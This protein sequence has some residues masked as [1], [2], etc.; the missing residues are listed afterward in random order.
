MIGDLPPNSPP[1]SRP[2]PSNVAAVRPLIRDLSVASWPTSGASPEAY[3]AETEHLGRFVDRGRRHRAAL[4]AMLSRVR[5]ARMRVLADL[6]DGPPDRSSPALAALLDAVTES[7]TFVDSVRL[8]LLET[9]MSGVRPV[10]ARAV[11][12][13]R[14]P[15]PSD[16][17]RDRVL[18]AILE[19]VG[20]AEAGIDPAYFP[21]AVVRHRSL[22]EQI[23]ELEAERGR[24]D[25][26]P[27][28][29][30]DGDGEAL[31]DLDRRLDEL[32]ARRDALADVGIESDG[33]IEPLDA[34]ALVAE[35]TGGSA[36]E[37]RY[38]ASA[39]VEH[40]RRGLAGGGSGPG[41]GSPTLVDTGGFTAEFDHLG[42]RVADDAV[43][44]AG[45][46][47]ELGPELSAELPT[48]VIGAERGASL[49]DA[50]PVLDQLASGLA[51]TTRLDG[52][53]AATL[54]FDGG[55]LLAQPRPSTAAGVVGHSPALLFAAG[56]FDDRFLADATITVLRLG[57]AGDP[58]GH[59]GRFGWH[60]SSDG[61][62]AISAVDPGED[63]R[64]L[65]L[66]RAAERPEVARLV[67]D[68]LDDG[69]DDG[70]DGGLVD[71]L[72]GVVGE[73]PVA[74][75]GLGPLV[76]PSVGFRPSM[77]PGLDAYPITA[78]L[79]AVAS[80][81]DASVRI[82]RAVAD[83]A[84]ATGSADEATIGDPGTAAGL[85]V[86]LGANAALVIDPDDVR[87][88]GLAPPGG[89]AGL[90]RPIDPAQWRAV[91]GEVHRWGRGE[92][93]AAATADLAATA[94]TGAIDADG[95][96]HVDRVAP[97][98]QLAG[99]AEAEAHR[100]RLSYAVG[101]DDEA[102]SWNRQASRTVAVANTALGL[103]PVV[104]PSSIPAGL[105]WTFLFEGRPTDA[106]LREHRDRWAAHYEDGRGHRWTSAVA[107]GWLGWALAGSGTAEVELIVPGRGHQV[108]ELR[109]TGQ[110]GRFHWRDPDTDAWSLLDTGFESQ[111]L[112]LAPHGSGVPLRR[113]ID[114]AIEIDEEFRDGIIAWR[115]PEPA[116]HSPSGD[117]REAMADAGWTDR[118]FGDR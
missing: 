49:A 56:R 26:L 59:A 11:L 74:E 71:G 116:P 48:F 24:V 23:A 115:L 3:R 64:N 51:S 18:A 80:D 27:L 106:E 61:L 33:S 41:D 10:L 89:G 22:T 21:S 63:P 103:V 112:A 81:Q 83:R 34:A 87:A 95:H 96:L 62:G 93:L 70:P 100:A 43:V 14:L 57:A 40:R 66:D 99:R 42:E 109:S 39:F 79:A 101:L 36:W 105:G 7:T 111:L 2:A 44:A 114:G 45:F 76:G 97:F 46:Y 8:D 84:A 12:D 50:R 77:V 86:L 52:N 118:W 35:T 31:A 53:G 65:L 58:R 78:F 4:E 30:W 1:S 88:V 5:E 90:E 110:P 113:A 91:V 68:G 17:L 20:P 13:G 47:R 54:G 94:I 32:A 67:V 82:V 75:G 15:P 19:G 107:S 108:V 28:V 117:D 104:G 29:W 60:W 9:T 37:G 69:S 85:D 38:Y 102:R 6:G 73:A 92:V 25:G 16:Q 55:D 98:A 72:D